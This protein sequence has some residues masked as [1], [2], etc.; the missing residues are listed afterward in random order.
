MNKIPGFLLWILIIIA[1]PG[2]FAQE[3]ILLITYGSDSRTIEGDNDH[4]QE[5]IIRIPAT[6]KDNLYLRIFDPDV[7]GVLDDKFGFHKGF[8][9]KTRFTLHGI[10]QIK[11]ET[12][13]ADETKDNAW[14]TFVR[15]SPKDGELRD[16][17]YFFKLRIEGMDGDDGNVFDVAVSETPDE[18]RK[19]AGVE[20]INYEPTIR[21]PKKGVSAEMRFFVPG[22]ASEIT[23]RGF[24]MAKAKVRV[25]TP[26]RSDLRVKS[27]G[28]DEWTDSK[29][30]LAEIENQRMFGLTF[31][32]GRKSPMT[33]PLR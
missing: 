33:P 5:I 16:D 14:H 10:S 17:H 20:M 30:K 12:F 29:I 21:L 7:G 2:V 9:T 32:G 19:P 26:F 4:Q 6:V 23:V 27:S 25:N 11:S 28:Q 22:D 1:T 15:F 13:A 8:D 3:N 31:T 24:D 18:N